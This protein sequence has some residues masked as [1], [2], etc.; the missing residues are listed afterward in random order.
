[1]R[2]MRCATIRGSSAVMYAAI[3]GSSGMP[4]SL[5]GVLGFLQLREDNWATETS[6]AIS[7]KAEITGGGV[8]KDAAGDDP[9]PGNFTD[10]TRGRFLEA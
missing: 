2:S 10:R 4:M 1:M 6:H 3:S 8:R 5:Q 9:G 7:A